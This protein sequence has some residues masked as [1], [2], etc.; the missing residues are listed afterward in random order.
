MTTDATH[1]LGG[2]SH[3]AERAQFRLLVPSFLRRLYESDLVSEGVDVRPLV[4]WV[5]AVILAPWGFIAVV[6]LVK[7]IHLASIVEQ[8]PDRF[9]ELERATWGDELFFILF[10]MTAVGL[11]T[12]L[13]WESVFP[14]KRDA[15]ILGSL[16]LRGRTV[17]L[18]KLTALVLFV[19]VFAVAISVPTGAGFALAVS[20][21][22]WF[23]APSYLLTHLV[24]T[25]LA[26]VFVFVF[27]VA[28]Q[29]L[30]A[31]LVHRRLVRAISITAQLLFVVALIEMFVYSTVISGGLAERAHTLA[32]SGGGSWLP[33]RWFLGLYETLL[34]SDLA[35]FHR[36]AVT[37]LVATGALLALSIAAYACSYRRIVRRE[38]ES[39][40][41]D[42][43]EPGRVAHLVC[44]I[45]PGVVRDRTELA[46]IAFIGKSLARSGL[47]RLVL[48]I[49]M[50]VALALALGGIL[51]P[52]IEGIG[53]TLDEPTVALLSIP[54]FLSFFALVGLR[55]LFTVPIELPANWVF[56]ITERHEKATYLRG[57]RTALVLIGLVPLALITLPA[58]WAIWDWQLAAAHTALWVLLG[59]LLIEALL[60]GF[61]KV[62]FTC[63]YL[64]GKANVRLLAPLY[65]AVTLIYGYSTARWEL[66]LLAESQRWLVAIAIL[67]AALVAVRVRRR[68]PS[69]P[70]PLLTYEETPNATIQL[71]LTRPV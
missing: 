47:H 3:D 63:S 41:P 17:L 31:A 25:P 66:W 15:Q 71:G 43:R 4:A 58:Y 53:V 23:A 64:P 21:H 61:R 54:L 56:Q 19:G 42:A 67:V 2:P 46:V 7:Y 52:L 24:V 27:L 69:S 37:A 34:G 36:L 45:W 20:W 8:F 51:R 22:H 50:G 40:Q 65:V 38:L 13:V 62:P 28:L 6:L 55:V 11:I 30:L 33:P 59:T 70:A 57:A 32:E 18:A 14:D 9:G 12:V 29:T 60:T 48:A 39:T 68:S 44:R 1:N 10:S 35:S 16:P 5:P 49:Y 26:G